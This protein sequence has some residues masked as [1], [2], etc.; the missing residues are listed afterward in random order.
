MKIL[1]FLIPSSAMISKI[2]TFRLEVLI[3]FGFANCEKDD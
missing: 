2:S 1:F 3:L